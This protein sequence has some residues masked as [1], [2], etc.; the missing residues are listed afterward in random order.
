MKKLVH[1]WEHKHT[2]E[3]LNRRW[4]KQQK[5]CKIILHYQPYMMVIIYD[6]NRSLEYQM[7]SLVV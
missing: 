3:I 6:K 7:I 1:K 5:Q 2:Q 4:Q